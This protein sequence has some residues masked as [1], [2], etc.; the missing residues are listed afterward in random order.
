MSTSTQSSL[1]RDTQRTTTIRIT[2][3]LR[4]DGNCREAMQF[5][6][7]SLGGNLSLMTVGESPEGSNMKGVNPNMIFHSSLTNENIELLGSDMAPE[8]GLV[9]GN[10]ISLALQCSSEE[11]LKRYFSKLSAGGKTTFAPSQTSWGAL[12]GQ[13]IDKFGREWMLTY[14]MK[15]G[16]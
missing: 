5:Y 6:K 14:F 3:Y 12:Y 15:Q 9:K 16:R 13:L 10:T 11:E 4:F 7:D 1:R 8:D 2:P